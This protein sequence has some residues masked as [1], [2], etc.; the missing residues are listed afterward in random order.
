MNNK[1]AIPRSGEPPVLS[2][3]A[4]IVPV[5][6]GAALVAFE[7]Q[8]QAFL[9]GVLSFFLT[10]PSMLLCLGSLIIQERPR[11]IAGLAF[12]ANA[13]LMYSLTFINLH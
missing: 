6:C 8:I 13:L 4:L 5:L 3:M 11:W 10:I 9:I 1:L 2:S 7:N 12:T